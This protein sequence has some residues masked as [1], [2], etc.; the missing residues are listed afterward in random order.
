MEYDSKN[1][2][3]SQE[4]PLE[5]RGASTVYTPDHAQK[6][7]VLQTYAGIVFYHVVITLAEV[8]MQLMRRSST[9]RGLV[10]RLLERDDKP[11]PM[12]I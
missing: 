8:S 6:H 11:D 2:L 4:I 7:S 3:C 9:V 1:R 12:F 5:H 10:E